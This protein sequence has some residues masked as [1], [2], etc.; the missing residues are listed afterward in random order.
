MDQNHKT[1]PCPWC[2]QNDWTELC[3]V[4]EYFYRCN[5]CWARSPIDLDKQKAV[6]L[7]E[8]RFTSSPTDM[9]PF[10]KQ[11]VCKGKGYIEHRCNDHRAH[12]R[13]FFPSKVALR[14]CSICGKFW[15]LYGSYLPGDKKLE[16]IAVDDVDTYLK[17]H[18]L[19]WEDGTEPT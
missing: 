6:L 5:K 3:E 16:W 10:S 15:D 12:V 11:C 14:Q 8:K 1:T 4:G 9:P 17:K 7:R 18:N 13:N 19:K 2:G